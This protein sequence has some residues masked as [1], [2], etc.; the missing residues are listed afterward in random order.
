MDPLFGRETVRYTHP[1]L[2]PGDNFG[3]YTIVNQAG[4]GAMGFV[5]RARDS[6][7]QRD[8]ALKVLPPEFVNNPDRK[9]RFLQEALAASSLA[10]PSIVVV[11]DAGRQDG[12]EF[13]AMEFV[14]GR[15]LEELIRSPGV[16]LR[17]AVRYATQIASALEAAHAAGII[18]R[19]LKPGNI[20]VTDSGLVKMLDFGLAKL[21]EKQPW[22]EEET[23]LSAGTIAGTILGTAAY[24]SPEQAEGRP[25]DA[26][27]DIFSFGSVLYEMLTGRPAFRGDSIL[28]TIAAILRDTP[29]PPSHIVADVPPALE[30]VVLNC[31]DKDPGRRFQNMTKVLESLER[32]TSD[33]SGSISDPSLLPAQSCAASIAVLPFANLSSDKENEYFSDGLAEEII[34]T[35]A[36]VPG[37]RVT[38]R[39]SAFAFR[40][41]EQ[42]VRTIAGKLNVETVLEGSVRR[43]GNRVRVAAQLIK[44]A[45]GYHLWSERYDR[46]LTDIFAL[47]DEI[48]AAIVAALCEHLGLSMTAP[49]C[50]RHTPDPQAYAAVL[51]GRYHRFRFTPQS[52]ELARRSFQEAVDRD[53]NYPDAFANLFMFHIA[54]WALDVIDPDASIAAAK[55]AAARALALDPNN[56]VTVAAMGTIRGAHDYDWEGAGRY[57]ARA[58]ELDPNSPD[59]LMQHG[60][61]YLRPLGRFHEARMQYRRVLEMDPLSSFAL[62]TIAE[63]YFFESRFSSMIEPA[64]K[65]LEIDPGYWPPMTMLATAY[66]HLGQHD[67][68]MKKIRQ[69]LELA[70]WDV[71]VRAITAS[72]Q[73][74]M[75]DLQPARKLVLEL[76]SQTG[77]ARVPAMLAYLYET[78]GQV[79]KELKV[80]EELLERRSARVFWVLAPSYTHLQADP[81]FPEML[82]R[83]NLTKAGSVSHIKSPSRR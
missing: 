12:V 45:D 42:D 33:R 20:M 7:L 4:S 18:H 59:V 27:S 76:E 1:M 6:R 23:L 48:A 38:A 39:T 31:M 19:D 26:R 44:A 72:L 43:S 70:P 28:S 64:L 82:R 9:Q 49:K 11:H 69:A 78:L 14:T 66:T 13:I 32:A 35:L 21:T 71:T 77:L 62:F 15:T 74:L 55:S 80:I 50:A 46:E 24:M 22:S 51:R 73:V 16:L 52:W 25:V 56:A 10:H 34:N 79:E 61:W 63:S 53:P 37:L 36:K 41:K 67:E 30:Q 54:E 17:D 60:Y 83:L 81:R 8:V 40:G 3:R 57:Y 75:G 58:L 29:A 47:Q 65:A 5:Y 2:S 68:A